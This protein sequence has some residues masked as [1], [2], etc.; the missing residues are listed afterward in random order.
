MPS[1]YDLPSEVLATIFKALPVEERHR[2]ISL[3]GRRWN[4]LCNSAPQLLHSIAFT[5]P[6]SERGVER[7]AAF[8]AWLLQHGPGRVQ[9]LSLE[10]MASAELH[11]VTLWHH[12]YAVLVA[13]VSACGAV[14]SLRAL[15]LR[16][17]C[18]LPSVWVR[19]MRS[20]RKLDLAAQPLEDVWPSVETWRPAPGTLVAL[21]QLALS[22]VELTID[23]PLPATLDQAA[24]ELSPVSRE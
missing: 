20:L 4:Q 19:A 11:Y 3:V 8:C 24:P 21:H 2:S 15:R 13:A 22:G 7:L 14:G 10:A 12:L 1:I 17:L 16:G 9:R 5:V 23:T 18:G 6:G